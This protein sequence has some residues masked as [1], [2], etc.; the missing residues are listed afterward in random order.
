MKHFY[1]TIL[2]S[3]LFVSVTSAQDCIIDNGNNSLVSPT[4]NIPAAQVGVYYEQVFQVKVPT[5][6]SIVYNNFNADGSINTFS[7]TS[8][9]NIPDGLSYSCNP[10]GCEFPGGSNACIK[11]FG[12]PTA[13]GTFYL[14]FHYSIDGTFLVFNNLIQQTVPNVYEDVEVTVLPANSVD[15]LSGNNFSIYPNPAKDGVNVQLAKSFGT[16]AQISI[17]NLL[18]KQ[19]YSSVVNAKEIHNIDITR[20][21]KGVYFVQV[22]ANGKEFTKKLIIK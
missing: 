16:N 8:I 19:V 17:V 6:T 5:D 11:V 7:I 18:G 2:L 9:D 13:S 14:D 4:E 15:E 21:E 22:V 12:T 1:T 20:F 10:S 3:L